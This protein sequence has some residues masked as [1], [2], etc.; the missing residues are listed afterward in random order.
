[1][2]NKEA[3]SKN[4][5]Y[6]FNVARANVERIFADFFYNK[7]TQL[8]EWPGTSKKTFIDFSANVTSAVIVYNVLKKTQNLFIH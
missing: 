1:M 3:Y 5:W 8:G 4:F 6:Q 2:E 7:F